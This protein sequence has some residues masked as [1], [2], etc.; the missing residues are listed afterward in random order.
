MPQ[1][2]VKNTLI[3]APLLDR[4]VKRGIDDALC[5]AL[6]E[7]I[8]Q[9]EQMRAFASEI[10]TELHLVKPILK[11]LGYAAESKPKFFEDQIKGADFALFRSDEERM[12]S[13]PQWGTRSYY[14]RVQAVLLVKRYGRRLTEGISGFYLE[15]ESRIP[16]YQLMYLTKKS[17]TPWG[18]LTNGKSW[19]LLEKP[20]GFEKR[21]LEIDL[22]TAVANNDEESLAL[23]YHAFSATGLEA[24]L[25]DLMERERTDVIGLLKDKRSSI[26]RNMPDFPKRTQSYSIALRLYKELFPK[27][28]LES[29]RAYQAE[30]HV[31]IDLPNSA[32]E[33]PLKS[34][35]Q[36]DILNYLLAQNIVQAAP[37]FEAVIR[38]TIAEEPVKENLLGLKILDM[39]CGFGNVAAQLVEAVAYLSFLLPYREKR[40]FVAEWEN[41]R[42]LHKYILD[43]VLYGIEKYHPALDVLQNGFSSRFDCG[44]KNFRV[45]NPLLGMSMSELCSLVKENNHQGILTRDPRETVSDLKEMYGRYFSLS[46]RIKEDAAEKNELGS[47]LRVYRQRLRETMNVMTASYF[48]NSLENNEIR[49]LLYFIEGDEDVWK[50]ARSRDW[51]ISA[52]EIA[53]RKNFF[54]MEI[55]F[56]FLLNEQFDLIVIQPALRYAWEDEVPAAEVA[57]AYIKRAM[58]YLKQTGRAVLVGGNPDE[59][60]AEFKKSRRYAVEAREGVVTV[61]RR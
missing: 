39:T 8:A 26:A 55:E 54:H 43:H 49:E 46:D 40:S 51:F 27:E 22:E 3:S 42:L 53:R 29:T 35:D 6:V 60:T 37:D 16:L 10:H 13:A 59:L 45:G 48:D 56:P 38:D 61:R 50:T 7:S 20:L 52:G 25:P 14:D 9:F 34:Y 23:F 30:A 2:L 28:S 18:I 15:F 5:T 57:K 1:S 31:H 19:V 32:R 17:G 44:A 12:R 41:E 11:I 33:L 4:L 47:T 36:S 21:V 24:T 58:T